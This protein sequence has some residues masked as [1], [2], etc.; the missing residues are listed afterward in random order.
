MSQSSGQKSERAERTQRGALK[1]SPRLF[2]KKGSENI[3]ALPNSREENEH[4][5]FESIFLS[6]KPHDRHFLNLRL[7][8][9]LL[10]GKYIWV[11]CTDA[12]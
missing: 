3:N 4:K 10:T 7:K 2:D 8:F 12:T 6:H 11:L 9:V 5:E 1:H